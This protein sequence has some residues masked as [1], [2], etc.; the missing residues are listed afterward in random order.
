MLSL[1]INMRFYVLYD[2]TASKHTWAVA[3][4][5]SDS[6]WFKLEGKEKKE[7]KWILK[8]NCLPVCLQFIQG[9]KRPTEL[10][11]VNK[12]VCMVVNCWS[13]VQSALYSSDHVPHM[14]YKST[15]I[16]E[17]STLT[18]TSSSSSSCKKISVCKGVGGCDE[19]WLQKHMAQ[20]EWKPLYPEPQNKHFVER[21]VHNSL[22]REIIDLLVWRPSK[23]I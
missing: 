12:T 5:F 10:R 9:M 18:E 11:A 13:V 6:S 4:I 16:G 7:Q 15:G 3:C 8:V 1:L 17:S 19:N 21:W 14:P 2:E 20:I 23:I 22:S